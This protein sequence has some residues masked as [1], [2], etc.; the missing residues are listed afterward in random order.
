MA[1]AEPKTKG[2][3]NRIEFLAEQGHC[4]CIHTAD[5]TDADKAE[6]DQANKDSGC[7]SDWNSNFCIHPGKYGACK[8]A[9]VELK[10]QRNN[11]RIKHSY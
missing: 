9:D 8:A 4:D 10:L 7:K 6:C 5:Y 1:R 3:E 2:K 11:K